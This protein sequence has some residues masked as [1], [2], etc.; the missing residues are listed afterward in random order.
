VLRSGSRRWPP[1]YQTLNNAYVGQRLNT[2]TN[3]VGKHYL[4]AICQGEFPAKEVQ[5]DHISPVVDPEQ[6]FVSWDVFIERLYCDA[7]N[8]Q[9][10][11]K[12]CHK[13]KSKKE[14]SG[15]KKSNQNKEG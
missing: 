2:K 15:R 9:T 6:G 1:R 5:I 7:D 3:R 8:M 10:V 11:C 14:S 4:C 12:P 13:I